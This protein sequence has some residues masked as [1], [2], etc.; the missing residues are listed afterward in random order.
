MSYDRASVRE[1]LDKVKAEGR[2]SLTPSECKTLCAAYGIRAAE[3]GI[4][5]LSAKEA[6]RI[7]ARNRISRSS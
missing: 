2:A 1:V 4:A 5:T 7:A 6:A 3:R